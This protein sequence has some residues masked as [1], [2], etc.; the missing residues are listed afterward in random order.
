MDS[1][2]LKYISFII[3][4]DLD[5]LGTFYAPSFIEF[6]YSKKLNKKLATVKLMN[7]DKRK[8]ERHHVDGTWMFGRLKRET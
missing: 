6:V 8:F 5:R 2:L 7:V 4:I 3:N 1:I